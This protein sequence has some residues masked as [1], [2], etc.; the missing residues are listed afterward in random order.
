[1]DHPSC[2]LRKRPG[3]LSCNVLV[4]RH[5]GLR[6]VARSAEAIGMRC[7]SPRLRFSQVCSTRRARFVR[8]VGR[9]GGER[10]WWTTRE[11]LHL[12]VFDLDTPSEAL[13]TVSTRKRG[14]EA[15]GNAIVAFDAREDAQRCA[16]ALEGRLSGKTCVEVDSC[17][18]RVLAFMCESSGSSC[19]VVP[20]GVSWSVPETLVDT[21]TW[22]GG[23]SEAT[24]RVSTQDL[25][26]F[27]SG[28]P[29]AAPPF[30]PYVVDEATDVRRAAAWC[31][32][33]AMLRHLRVLP[34][35][36]SRTFL[37]V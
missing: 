12:V 19:E 13:L 5:Q 16:S 31:V 7:G 3:N 22:E 17:S 30:Q 2:L 32:R 33:D 18:P 1:M 15:P 6:H 20:S 8:W 23:A 11:E 34:L 35:L 10:A 26:A 27:L 25:Q 4:V 37:D 9:A 36:L 28:P 29:P 21:R 24:L 14:E